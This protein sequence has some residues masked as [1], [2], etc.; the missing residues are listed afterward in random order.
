MNKVS[1]LVP[2]KDHSERVTD[3]NLK[4]FNG[5]PL[6]FKILNVL[7]KLKYASEILVNTDSD[8]ISNLISKNFPSIK[9]IKRPKEICGDLVSMNTI[10]KHDLSHSEG[11]FFLQTHSTNPLLKLSTLEKAIETFFKSLGKYDSLFSVTSYR[12]RFFDF[13]GSAINHDLSKLLRTQDLHPVYE[14]N[15][16][17]YIFSKSSFESNGYNR[18][19]KKPMMFEVD[20]VEA[21]DID[22]P[23][24]FRIA[25]LLD[26]YTK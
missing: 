18:I 9:I 16:C 20:K 13:K 8:R 1:V 24:D 11:E 22:W 4:N 19:G 17:F 2:M 12:S 10:I 14:E 15:S 3:K 26:K 25:E 7:E 23:D 6:C 21:I 5:V